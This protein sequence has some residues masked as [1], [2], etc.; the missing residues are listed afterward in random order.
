MTALDRSR[1]PQAG[2]LRPFRF[3]EVRRAALGNG[4]AV[5]AARSGDLPLVSVQLVLDAGAMRDGDAP[6]GVASL[7]AS[8]LESGTAHRTAEQIALLVDELGISLE[9]G[10]SWDGVS[11]G[12]TGLRSR[13]EPAFEL[14]ADLARSPVFPR[15]EVD[16]LKQERIG[17]LKHRRADP[18]A[19][20]GEVFHL[21]AFADGS[22]FARPLG[23][24]GESIEAMDR[25]AVAAFHAA[26]YGP[27]GGTVLAA[28]DIQLDDLVALADRHLGDWAA[29]TPP[30]PLPSV[31]A[32][33]DRTTIV[34]AHRPGAVQSEIRLG[35][36]GV[37][38]LA[39]DFAALQV[40]NGI[41]GGTFSSRLNLNLRERLGYTYGASSSWTPRRVP[42]TFSMGA[43]VQTEATAHSVAEMLREMR[44][45][46]DAPPT[47]AEVEDARSYLAG[48]LPLSVETTSGVAARLASIATYG[49]PDDYWDGYRAQLLEV[50]AEAAHAAAQARLQ[51]GRAVVAVTADADRV[52]TEL[53]ALD[54]GPVVVVDPA[55]VLR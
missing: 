16:R 15:P 55:A 39:P 32:G 12:F 46:Q 27:T 53:E 52:R 19:L 23:G 50:S 38:R 47:G 11:I 4:L 3:P 49:L 7:T 35:H 2:T 18:G 48:V 51:P 54:A 42:G 24:T 21:Y 33:V 5:L 20:A 45:M 25:E 9:V 44:G 31:E 43:A 1:A 30:G 10:A 40:M 34:I 36:L 8:L 26:R 17:T 22:P 6:A 37:D 28:G 14:L 13:L 29:S 41:L